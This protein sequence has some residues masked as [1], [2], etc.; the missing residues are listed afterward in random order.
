MESTISIE[1]LIRKE[2]IKDMKIAVIDESPLTLKI[3]TDFLADL[4]HE[5]SSFSSVIDLKEKQSRNP[6]TVDLI[7]VGLEAPKVQ[8]QLIINEINEQYPSADI[9][10]M[11]GGESVLDSREAVSHRVYSYLKKPVR[12][13]EL[14]LLITRVREKRSGNN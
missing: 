9:V 10:I 8:D 3:I 6:G 11:S 5:G 1:T 12:L 2:K 14:E 7:L 4:G 13:A